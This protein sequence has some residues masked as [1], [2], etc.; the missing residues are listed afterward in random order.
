MEAHRA[1]NSRIFETA[2]SPGGS[3]AAMSARRPFPL[4]TL[5]FCF[6]LWLIT[7]EILVFDQV[8]FD[9]KTQLLEQAAHALHGPQV[10]IPTEPPSNVPGGAK[11][12]RL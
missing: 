4:R 10:L 11:M 5:M 2:D 1:M 8:K 6:T 7:T 3:A 9:A 12:E